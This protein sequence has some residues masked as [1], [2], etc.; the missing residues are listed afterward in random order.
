MMMD[1]AEGGVGVD[2]MENGW[3]RVYGEGV[4]IV[5]SVMW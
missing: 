5:C 2:E 3:W 4:T 1:S